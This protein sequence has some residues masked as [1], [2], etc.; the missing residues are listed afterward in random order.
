M[1]F[2]K[3]PA[4]CA[5]R[6][7]TR[8]VHLVD[9]TTPGGVMRY[10]DFLRADA[11][12][13]KAAE[14]ILRP[15]SRGEV[16]RLSLDCEVI[17]SH[18]SVNWRALPSLIALRARNTAARLI[19]VEH[20][21][22]AGFTALNVPSR[23][24]FFTLLRS[25]YALFD[26]VVAVSAAQGEWLRTRALV[27]WDRLEIIRPAV[28]LSDFASLPAPRA[29][30]RVIGAFGR[31][32]RQKG[33]DTLILAFRRIPGNDRVLRLHGAGADLAMLKSLAAGDARI[34]FH[35]HVA[36]PSRAMSEVD[37]V[38]MPSRWEAYGIAALEA[39]VAGRPLV[40]TS[41]DGLR[42]HAGPGVTL[43]RPG[44]VD[45]LAE[46]LLVT[47]S[48]GQTSAE[49]DALATLSETATRDGWSRLTLRD[50]HSNN[51]RHAKIEIPS[52]NRASA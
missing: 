39:R 34:Q 21:Y 42:D 27:P 10:L 28:D 8:V 52:L 22:T 19:H 31:L 5:S 43:V 45:E 37:I 41:V 1:T 47:T 46:A 4:L 44:A 23:T 35:G 49:R 33:F 32:D 7:L 12:L 9:D 3:D 15:V 13:A 20:S 25:A 30:P 24:R 36:D 16:G 11:T 17:V 14:H 40:A 6:D 38:A 2:L 48:S 51:A 18:L 29:Q 26:T 50:K